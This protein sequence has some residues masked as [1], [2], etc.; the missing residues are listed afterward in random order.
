MTTVATELPEKMNSVL[1][2]GKGRNTMAIG[3][4]TG[5]MVFQGSFPVAFGMAFTPWNISQSTLISAFLAI[6][7]L[8]YFYIM[9]KKSGGLHFRDL[10]FGGAAYA[11]FIVHVFFIN[12]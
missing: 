10:L 4:I 1:W 2:L 5:A 6:I 3:N 11:G 7:S 12:G 8:L 9:L